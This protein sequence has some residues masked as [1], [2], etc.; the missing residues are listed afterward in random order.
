MIDAQTDPG[1]TVAIRAFLHAGP[2]A[3]T[4]TA[5]VPWIAE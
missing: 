3:L 2:K 1:V 4:E 5:L